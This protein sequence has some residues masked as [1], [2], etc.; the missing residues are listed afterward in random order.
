M[1]TEELPRNCWVCPAGKPHPCPSGQHAVAARAHAAK[2]NAPVTDDGKAMF[3]Y[4]Y[5]LGWV[6]VQ[7]ERGRRVNIAFRDL[8]QKTYK[9]VLDIIDFLLHSGV[10]VM[11]V[12]SP[13]LY[14]FFD[15]EDR[16][17]RRRLNTLLRDNDIRA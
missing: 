17:W 13:E 16:D 14:E 12:C 8:N 1:M 4:L 9:W 11:V 15:C 6:R 3:T 7:W 5:K 10:G 2:G